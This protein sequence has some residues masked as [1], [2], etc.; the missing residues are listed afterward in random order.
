MLTKLRKRKITK[1]K[2]QNT[3][4]KYTLTYNKRIKNDWPEI[5]NEQWNKMLKDCAYKE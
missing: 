5:T 1:Q 3:K 2:N 4:V